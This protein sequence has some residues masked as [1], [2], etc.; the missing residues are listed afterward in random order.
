[1]SDKWSGVSSRPAIGIRPCRLDGGTAGGGGS[2]LHLA[3]ALPDNG[4]IVV[5]ATDACLWDY[6]SLASIDNQI[7]AVGISF[8]DETGI[9]R[10]FYDFVI[11]MQRH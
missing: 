8:G 3:L 1:M 6:A 11:I 2:E 9:C 10:I 4:E 5:K 7:H